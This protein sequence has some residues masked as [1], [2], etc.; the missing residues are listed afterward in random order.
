M[1]LQRR[2]GI[3]KSLI[4]VT[5]LALTGTITSCAKK[6]NFQQSSV[7]PGADGTVRVKQDGNDNYNIKVTIKDLA[8]VDRLESSKDTY[9]VWMDTR[10]GTTENLG[11]LISSS[12]LFSSQKTASLETVSSYEPVRIFV[13]AEQGRNVNY[14]GR[15]IVLTTDSF[16]DGLLRRR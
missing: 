4:I 11:Q 13:T 15:E 12:G 1:K 2:S 16:R 8:T 10:Q 7:V 14:P 9:V 6:V 5:I 3:I